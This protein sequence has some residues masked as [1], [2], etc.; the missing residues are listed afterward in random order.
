MAESASVSWQRYWSQ[1][2]W[3]SVA[4]KGRQTLAST[5]MGASGSMGDDAEWREGGPR[6]GLLLVVTPRRPV[7][8]ADFA[9]GLLMLCWL[10][11]ALANYRQAAGGV[12]VE[13]S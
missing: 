9:G 1:Y 3:G 8:D 4:K 7:G 2:G 12:G 5:S 6:G 13:L 10:L 11:L